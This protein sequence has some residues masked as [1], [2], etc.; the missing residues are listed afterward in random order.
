LG[1]RWSSP[2][3]IRGVAKLVVEVDVESS[4]SVEEILGVE[5][6]VF[7]GKVVAV[8]LVSAIASLLVHRERVVL[9]RRVFHGKRAVSVWAGDNLGKVGN[10]ERVVLDRLVQG[11][12]ELPVAKGVRDVVRTMVVVPQSLRHVHRVLDRCITHS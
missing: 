7:E 5:D 9:A 6:S 8:G 10:V 2:G 4:E 11:E 1:T 3:N 12:K